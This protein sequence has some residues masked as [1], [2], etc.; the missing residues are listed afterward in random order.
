MYICRSNI[1]VCIYEHFVVVAGLVEMLY[2][3]IDLLVGLVVH[4]DL[5]LQ[6]YM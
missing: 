3:P 4:V 2:R 5:D 1:H 6:P